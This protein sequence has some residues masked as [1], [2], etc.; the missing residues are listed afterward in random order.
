MTRLYTEDIAVRRG[1]VDGVEGP[2]QFLWGQRLYAVR[3][4]LDQW[5][6][7]GSW[8]RQSDHR[9]AG[10]QLG[11]DDRERELWRVEASA[12]RSGPVGVFDLCFSWSDGRWSLTRVHD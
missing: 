12:G 7:A 2:A 3:A 6:E 8:W 1:E 10:A 5:V 4:V 11:V 9:P